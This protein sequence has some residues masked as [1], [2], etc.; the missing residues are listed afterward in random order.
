VNACI[1]LYN[2]LKISQGGKLLLP[3]EVPVEDAICCRYAKLCNLPVADTGVKSHSVKGQLGGNILLRTLA[4][5]MRGNVDVVRKGGPV[6]QLARVKQCARAPVEG[7][8]QIQ[9]TNTE[10]KPATKLPV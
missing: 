10:P 4:N 2:R 8:L 3:C 7:R 9:D 1:L 5:A 6:C